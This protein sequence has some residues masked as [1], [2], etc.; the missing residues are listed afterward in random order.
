MGKDDDMGALIRLAGENAGRS[1][2]GR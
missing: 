2:R 1:V